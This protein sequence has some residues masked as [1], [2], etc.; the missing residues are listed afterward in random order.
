M[1]DGKIEI[2]V[3]HFSTYGVFTDK[4]GPSEFVVKEISKT[5]DTITLGLSAYDPSG[6]K[7]Y[8]IYRNGKEIAVLKGEENTFTDSKLK[9]GTKYKYTAVAVDIRSEEHTS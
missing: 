3:D 4:L 2:E 6:I 1:K 7:E 8:K 5:T 9:P